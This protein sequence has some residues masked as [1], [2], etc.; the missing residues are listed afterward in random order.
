[1]M[2]TPAKILS[3]GLFL[4]DRSKSQIGDERT[5]CLPIGQR[6]RVHRYFHWHHPL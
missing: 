1:M 3:L 2:V 5:S 4:V 6:L